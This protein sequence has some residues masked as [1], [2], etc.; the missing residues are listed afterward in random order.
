M[1]RIAI[2]LSMVV[3]GALAL[4]PI[5]GAQ[6]GPPGVVAMN[7]TS[8]NVSF[9]P[10]SESLDPTGSVLI[11]TAVMTGG[12][13]GS[14]INGSLHIEEVRTRT[15]DA[16]S[17]SVQGQFTLTDNFGSTISG[18]LSGNFSMAPGSTTASGQ[19]TIRGGTGPFTGATGS[20][21]FSSTVSEPGV[22][23]SIVTLSS[24]SI[25]F[26]GVPAATSQYPGYVPPPSYAPAYVSPPSYTAPSY[27][28]GSNG[29]VDPNYAAAQAQ[30][31][32]QAAAAQAQPQVIIVPVP[33]SEW[34]PNGVFDRPARSSSTNRNYR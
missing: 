30:A 33:E 6:Y 2:S 9:A 32:A 29:Y 10:G 5:A 22:G 1:R 3:L 34:D 20:G 31:A 15:V 13:V 17:G 23:P 7:E 19:F 27:T 26:G 14:P 21:S 16:G 18:D 28:W 4:A 25:S 24:P 12:V 11:T 8:S